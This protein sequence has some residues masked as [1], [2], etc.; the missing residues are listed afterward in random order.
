M[1]PGLSHQA[2][3]A[4]RRSIA[5]A[6]W[7]RFGEGFGFQACWSRVTRAAVR[8]FWSLHSG[9]GLRSPWTHPGYSWHAIQEHWGF[10][11]G[12]TFSMVILAVLIDIALLSLRNRNH[13]GVRSSI[14]FLLDAF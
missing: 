9:L 14:D 5:V 12:T 4:W 1:I 2:E 13:P 3:W 10:R 11:Q 6:G 7:S 8:I